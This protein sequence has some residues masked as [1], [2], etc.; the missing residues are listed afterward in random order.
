LNLL[1]H[2]QIAPVEEIRYL[3]PLIENVKHDLKKVQLFDFDNHSEHLIGDYAIRLINKASR[4]VI[5]IQNTPR[6]ERLGV[7]MD[8]LTKL[9]R[10][11]LPP[12]LILSQPG[13]PLL[14]RMIKIV[15]NGNYELDEDLSTK[16]E[17]IISFFE[18]LPVYLSIFL[19][20][21]LSWY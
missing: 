17:R 18:C 11:K 9:S 12:L 16:R 3:L 7:V 15:S 8:F 14:L 2:I 13:D 10:L 1:I 5:I 4:A 20:V 19:A 21:F 6:K